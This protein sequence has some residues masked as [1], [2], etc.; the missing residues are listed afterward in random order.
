MAWMPVSKW[1]RSSM[2]PA[3]HRVEQ[4]IGLG[5][6]EGATVPV[7]GRGTMVKGYEGGYFVKPTILADVPRGSEISKTEIFGPVLEPDACQYGG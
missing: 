7:D 1:D 2:P 6:K 4:L 3:R 5:V